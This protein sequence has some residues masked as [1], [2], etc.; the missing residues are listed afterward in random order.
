[1]L[2]GL[3]FLTQHSLLPPTALKFTQLPDFK[4]IRDIQQRKEIFFNYF[5]PL[6]QAE[7]DRIL[8]LRK[9]LLADID[10]YSK[11]AELNQDQQK[12]LEFLLHDFDVAVDLPIEEQLA[13][14]EKR[15]NVLPV[16][17][18]LA[19]AAKESAWG[20]SRFARKGNNF[21]GEWCYEKGCGMVPTNRKNTATHEVKSFD[22]P[23]ESVQSYFN[24][25]NTHA[26]YVGL[27]DLRSQTEKQGIAVTGLLLI[28]ELSN[29][30][31]RR[32]KYIDELRSIIMTNNLHDKFG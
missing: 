30:S 20:R 16:S 4:A 10:D 11:K 18:V 7:N 25:I 2:G 21:F 13:E 14:L 31:E 1:M 32:D 6:I 28:K 12:D 3:L 5:L 29:Y 8:A 15:V 19:Q 24:N 9:K 22:Y 17:M 27:R 26:A 23:I